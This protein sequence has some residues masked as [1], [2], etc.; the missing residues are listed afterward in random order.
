LALLLHFLSF[1]RPGGPARVAPARLVAHAWRRINDVKPLSIRCA[2]QHRA[3]EG[4]AQN[5]RKV[6][7]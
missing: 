3:D 5:W 1:A 4:Y 7:S 6:K 2:V